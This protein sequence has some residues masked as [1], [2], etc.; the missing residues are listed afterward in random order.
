MGCPRL[1]TDYYTCAERRR[2]T[3]LNKNSSTKYLTS[4]K[5]IEKGQRYYRFG[6][7]TQEKVDEIAGK[8]NHNTAL[9]GELDTR[10]GRRWNLDPKPSSS[11][12]PYS[13]FGNSPIYMNDILLDTPGVNS[14]KPNGAPDNPCHGDIFR[15][16][17]GTGYVF[18]IAQEAGGAWIAGLSGVSVSAKG[19][20]SSSNNKNVRQAAAWDIGRNDEMRNKV[21]MVEK[22]LVN[23][24]YAGL[25]VVSL[26]ASAIA[27]TGV[28]L[29]MS[30]VSSAFGDMAGQLATN[31]GDF[32]KINLT[33]IMASGFIGN[34]FVGES[35]GQGLSYSSARGFSD[36]Y[37]LGGQ[38]T[39]QYIS[40]ISIAGAGGMLQSGM[41]SAVFTGM[42]TQ[43][44]ISVMKDYLILGNT[45]ARSMIGLGNVIS[46]SAT[47]T[48]V[49]IA[50]DKAS[51]IINE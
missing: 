12:S 2:S 15:S 7:N 43:T 11:T 48:G 46:N 22:G 33:Y 16:S 32:G 5:T 38:S 6:F 44:R 28:G 21:N 39:A 4:K 35:I 31:G 47:K 13:V 25:T 45:R 9:F 8:G 17:S 10:L 51:D 24:L 50:Q 34:P 27:T 18:D 1:H 36:S 37:L 26:G 42:G 29:T 30:R 40:N 14:I 41:N 3:E 23:T 19:K 20:G 49:N